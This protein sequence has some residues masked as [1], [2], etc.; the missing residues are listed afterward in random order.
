M[1]HPMQYLIQYVLYTSRPLM[2]RYVSVCELIFILD[3]K[4]AYLFLQCSG[5]A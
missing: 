5:E 1:L 3:G 4:T 2:L